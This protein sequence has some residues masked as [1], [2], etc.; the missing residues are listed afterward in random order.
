MVGTGEVSVGH[1]D[2]ISVEHDGLTLM[3]LRDDGWEILPITARHN[4]GA[5]Q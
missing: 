2:V 5:F 3:S 1:T 4:V